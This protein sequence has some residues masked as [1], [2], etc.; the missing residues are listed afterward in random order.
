M[1]KRLHQEKVS[2]PESPANRVTL[3]DFEDQLIHLGFSPEVAR[4][5]CQSF[6]EGLRKSLVRGEEV[7]LRGF[8]NFRRMRRKRKATGSTAEGGGADR[9]AYSVKF[10]PSRR[11]IGLLYGKEIPETGVFLSL[12]EA[13]LQFLDQPSPPPEAPKPPKKKAVKKLAA[14]DV[15]NVPQLLPNITLVPAHV[16][17]LNRT[18]EIV[19]ELPPVVEFPEPDPDAGMPL[20]EFVLPPGL[21]PEVDTSF[22]VESTL[23]LGSPPPPP[24]F[25]ATSAPLP[26]L[27]EFTEP[28]VEEDDEE[29][30]DRSRMPPTPADLEAAEGMDFETHYDL[31]ISYKEMGLYEQSVRELHR[32]IQKV[33]PTDEAGRYMSC[34]TLLGMCYRE[35]QMY[36]QSVDWFQH[37][38]TL[39]KPADASYLALQY[40]LGLTYEMAGQT[41]NALAAFSEVYALDVHFR[42]VIEKVRFLQNEVIVRAERMQKMIPIH[43]RAI[44]ARGQRMDEDTWIVNISRRGAGLK[45]NI[46]HE[47][48]TLIEVEFTQ[49]GKRHLGKVVWCAPSKD[50]DSS[51]RMGITLI[52]DA[53]LGV[54]D[55]PRPIAQG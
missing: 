6:M 36:L 47:S 27:E 37:A 25:V 12:D 32:A 10:R 1:S 5:V 19:F 41:F 8:G 9:Y 14:V 7:K 26:S 21:T 39:T 18:G 30:R 49:A 55:W 23:R 13:L 51:Y 54:E 15:E 42:E 38:L 40:E 17:A 20:I 33:S 43:I 24:N 48:G 2:K 53:E 29:P 46:E 34:C 11:L 4:Q 44:D 16:S 22:E 35:Q 31:G 50:Q 45:T 52:T 3:L 28:P